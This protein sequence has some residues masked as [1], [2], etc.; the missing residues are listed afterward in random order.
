[1]RGRD[2]AAKDRKREAIIRKLLSHDDEIGEVILYEAA[3]WTYHLPLSDPHAYL[4]LD[5]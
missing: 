4:D 2:R 5:R 3:D 1:M